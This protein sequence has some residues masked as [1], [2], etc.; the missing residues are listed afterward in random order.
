MERRIF[1]RGAVVTAASA[2]AGPALAQSDPQ[3]S[4]PPTR[5]W[6][7]PSTAIYP[8]PAFQAFDKRFEKYNGGTAGLVRIWTGGVWTEGP[9]W[10]GDMDSLIFSD[11]PNDKLM[12]YDATTRQ[13][14]VFRQASNF[15]N[16]NTRDRQG[17]L[18]GATHE[19]LWVEPDRLLLTSK[20]SSTLR[21]YAFSQPR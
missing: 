11:I 13:T 9:V 17:R 16:G 6:N 2:V 4:V 20:Q 21:T 14:T 12:R 18:P 1:M 19:K 10:F 5:D 15:T 7:D 3:G 8:D